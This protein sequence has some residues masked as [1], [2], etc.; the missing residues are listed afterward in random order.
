MGFGRATSFGGMGWEVGSLMRIF[1]LGDAVFEA[2]GFVGEGDRI[3]KMAAEGG[4]ARLPLLLRARP[5]TRSKK[6]VMLKS[7]GRILCS[8]SLHMPSISCF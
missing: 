2:C 4:G 3:S 5:T 8:L 1:L 7:L 6:I